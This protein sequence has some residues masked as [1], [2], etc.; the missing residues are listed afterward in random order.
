MR[1]ENNKNTNINFNIFEP[2]ILKNIE[3]ATILKIYY[4][5]NISTISPTFLTD[6]KNNTRNIIFYNSKYNCAYSSKL[7]DLNKNTSKLTPFLPDGK[8]CLRGFLD[9]THNIN[10]I[11]DNMGNIERITVNDDKI[12]IL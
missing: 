1:D 5:D 10:T 4:K 11:Y 2:S 6:N 12:N 8:I 3:E 9:L 7:D